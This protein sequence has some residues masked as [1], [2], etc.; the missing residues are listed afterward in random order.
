M[1]FH[2]VEIRNTRRYFCI[3]VYKLYVLST[4]PGGSTVEDG[5][6][7]SSHLFFRVL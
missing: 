2:H 7:N 1:K 4:L 6:G 3:Q 5:V